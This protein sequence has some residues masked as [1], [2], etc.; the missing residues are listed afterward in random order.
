MLK[1]KNS[2]CRLPGARFARPIAAPGPGRQTVWCR[3]VFAR[4]R[5]GFYRNQRCS[6]GDLKNIGVAVR[7]GGRLR[8]GCEGHACPGQKV[9]VAWGAAQN[10]PGRPEADRRVRVD[11]Q[12]SPRRGRVRLA[13]GGARRVEPPEWMCNATGIGEKKRPRGVDTGPAL[14]VLA[15]AA[16]QYEYPS[17][18]PGRGLR[19]VRPHAARLSC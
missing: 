13:P 6:G 4:Q 3:R 10:V 16:G 17:H 9:T 14:Q 18:L 1:G 15:H 7:E 5:G 8:P 19:V 12:I 11:R 2:L